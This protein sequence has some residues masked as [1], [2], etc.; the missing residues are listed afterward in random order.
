M[1]EKNIDDNYAKT[2]TIMSYNILSQKHLR[3]HQSLYEANQPETL[4]WPHRIALIR[5]EVETIAPEILCVQEIEIERLAEIHEELKVLNFAQPLFKKRGGLQT[6]GCAIFFNDSKFRLIEEYPIDY[7]RQ[8]VRVSWSDHILLPSQ[9]NFMISIGRFF[10][11]TKS[12]QCCD[13]R[14]ICTPFIVA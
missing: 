13:G 8:G 6:D 4:E 10:P 7:F 5:K 9:P 12:M 3:T 11:V 1:T 14:Q 2:F